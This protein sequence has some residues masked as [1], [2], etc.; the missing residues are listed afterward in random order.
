VSG[1]IERLVETIRAQGLHDERL[2]SAIA[3]V[4]RADFVPPEV[5]MR[6]A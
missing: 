4:P 5:T 2:L 1:S 6:V 3:A